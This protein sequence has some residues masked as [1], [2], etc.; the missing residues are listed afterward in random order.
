[1]NA[2]DV[3]QGTPEWFAVRYGM[4]TAS[5]FSRIVTSTGK[6]STSLQGYAAELAA[7]LFAGKKLDEFH[8]NAWMD[9]GRDMEAE[10][11]EMYAFIT[12]APVQKATFYELPDRSAGCSPDGLVGDDGLIE[13]KCLKAERHVAAVQYHAK[14]G[15]CPTDYVQQTQGQLW[16]CERK[17]CDL[18]FFH[19][20][21]PP[22]VIRQTPDAAMQAALAAGVAEVIRERDAALASMRAAP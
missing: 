10:A 2:R 13:I 19:P 9:R 4:P 3:V 22:L 18:M 7:E 17:W 21:L 16:I 14:H 8:G 15:K 1:M 5:Q 6:P 20:D 12:D 11:F